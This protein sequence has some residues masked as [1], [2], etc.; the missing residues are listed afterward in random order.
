MFHILFILIATGKDLIFS[1]QGF[2]SSPPNSCNCLYLICILAKGPSIKD[3]S[4]K[5]EGG[6]TPKR[7][8]EEMGGGTLFRAEETSFLKVKIHGNVC[9]ISLFL[10]KS[11][12]FDLNLLRFF[13]K[14]L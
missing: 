1:V 2:N 3:V 11:N 14:I 10:T 12:M 7:R 9:S 6:G 5:G 4:P 8:R 13:V